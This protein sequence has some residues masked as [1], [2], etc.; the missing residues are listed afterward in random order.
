MQTVIQID[1]SSGRMLEIPIYLISRRT[2]QPTPVF[3][4]GES[5]GQRRLVGHSPWGHK[6]SDMTE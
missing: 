3:L 2:W 1:V 6:E 5:Q 4:L